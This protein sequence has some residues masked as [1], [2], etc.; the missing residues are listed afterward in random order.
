MGPRGPIFFE[1]SGR[2]RYEERRIDCGGDLKR[3]WRQGVYQSTTLVAVALLLMI[4]FVSVGYFFLIPQ[5]GS[6]QQN[7]ELLAQMTLQREHWEDM[8]P[9]SFRYVVR[10]SCFC[11]SETVTPYVAKEER[12]YKTVEYRVEL[13]SGPGKFLK[14][15]RDPLWID[16]IFVELAD[17]LA[18]E[19]EPLVDVT[20]DET[21]GYPETVNIVYPQPDAYILYS[22][23]DFEIIEHR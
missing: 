21:L 7:T 10:R 19:H 6:S 1:L 16:N 8:R 15:P 2:I 9:S 5:P 13:E 17:A 14:S 4:L 22:I 20:Y 18:S 3:S 12:G 11:D 23:H